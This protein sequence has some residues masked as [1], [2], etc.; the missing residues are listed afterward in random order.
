MREMKKWMLAAILVC[1]TSVF[2]ACTSDND[3]T[4]APVQPGSETT[5][6]ELAVKCINGT[7]IGKKTDNVI[8]YKGIPFVG[9]QPVGNLRWKAPVEY[10]A[11]NGVYEAYE[12]AK[13]ACQAEG[14]VP[15]M[16]EDCLYLNVWKAE[17]TSAEKK[18]VMVWIHG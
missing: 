5:D 2:T 11:D 14:V 1:G 12:N 16:G 9:Q 3:D 10:T 18:P 15:S 6:N 8:A 13:G 17:D 4:P 7:F